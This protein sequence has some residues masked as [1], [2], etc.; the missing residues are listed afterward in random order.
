MNRQLRMILGFGA[1]G[2]MKRVDRSVALIKP[3]QPYVDWV[4][5]FRDAAEQKTIQDLSI[6]C[7]QRNEVG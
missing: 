4:N 5:G 1:I 6:E 3:R 7:S 2:S